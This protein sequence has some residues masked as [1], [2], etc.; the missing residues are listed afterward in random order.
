M[1]APVDI[2]LM[3]RIAWPTGGCAAYFRG[4]SRAS[5]ECN[6]ACHAAL[7]LY[8]GVVAGV[9]AHVAWLHDCRLLAKRPTFCAVAVL[10]TDVF[11]AAC[12]CAI[13]ATP[14]ALIAV[15]AVLAVLATTAITNGNALVC[16]P[17][18]ATLAAES[19]SSDA[20]SLAASASAIG[21]DAIRA[22]TLPAAAA[23]L[24]AAG[25]ATCHRDPPA[26]LGSVGRMRARGLSL[27]TAPLALRARGDTSAF[28]G[29]CTSGQTCRRRH[30]VRGDC[31]R[32]CVGHART[33]IEYMYHGA[34]GASQH[35][36]GRI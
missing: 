34:G 32:R 6:V 9:P 16:T 12:A 36:L 25:T 30:V 5:A 15:V 4:W 24:R 10:P 13:D 26:V 2:T 18:D 23:A 21:A 7:V 20:A 29:I 31:T 8:F 1:P 33:R 11:A 17:L 3:T 28:K 22:A 35:R 19:P 27:P 14:S